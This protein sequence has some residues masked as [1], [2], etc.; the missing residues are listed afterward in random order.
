VTNRS[1]YKRLGLGVSRFILPLHGKK[2]LQHLPTLFLALTVPEDAVV[3]SNRVSVFVAVV[4]TVDQSQVSGSCNFFEL[5]IFHG[6]A[7]W[8]L[9]GYCRND[10]KCETAL[11]K[12]FGFLCTLVAFDDLCPSTRVEKLI[13][14]FETKTKTA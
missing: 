3:T 6:R 13:W 7:R 4:L 1:I 12:V 8:G 10:V 11:N 14:V 2:F 5:G 9:C